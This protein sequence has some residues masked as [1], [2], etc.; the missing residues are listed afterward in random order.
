MYNELGNLIT[1]DGIPFTYDPAKPHQLT[2]AIGGS[3]TH[4][5]NG[6]RLTKAA[7]GQ[8]YTYD[9]DDRVQTIAAGGP[10]VT[11]VYDYT[12][13]RVAQDVGGNVTRYYSPLIEVTKSGWLTKYYTVAG[14][15]IASQRESAPMELAGLPRDPAI[16]LARTD[17]TRPELLFVLRDD[18]QLPLAL[19]VTLLGTTL[20]LAP[21]K[22]KR[23]VGI[24]IR[25]G[26]VIL[27]LMAYGVTTFPLPIFVEPAAAATPTSTRTGTRTPTSTPTQTPTRTA[28]NTATATSTRTPTKTATFTFT[29]TPTKTATPTITQTPTRTATPTQTGTST[30]T[31]TVTT[32]PTRTST[33]TPTTTPTSTATA[34]GGSSTVGVFHYH[35]DHLGSTQAVTDRNG[36]VT[37]YARYA[38]YG[39]PRGHYKADGSAQ[40]INNCSDDGYCREYTGYDTEPISGL[41]Y[42]GARV[43]DPVLGTFLTHDPIPGHPNPYSYVAWNPINE[44][45]PNGECIW[46]LCLDVILI[47]A[48]VGFAVSSIQA[49]ANGATVGQALKAGAIGG[50]IGAVSG[51]GLSVLEFAITPAL[52]PALH[53]LELAGGAY[54][55][56]RGFQSGQYVVGA[57]GVIGIA[58]GLYGLS[59]DLNG[60]AAQGGNGQEGWIPDKG[61]PGSQE[62]AYWKSSDALCP[63][64]AV[65]APDTNIDVTNDPLIREMKGSFTATQGDV[66][67]AQVQAVPSGSIGKGWADTFGNNVR[68]RNDLFSRFPLTTSTEVVGHEFGHVLQWQTPFFGIRYQI[69]TALHGYMN[70]PFEV[71]ADAMGYQFA[72]SFAGR[73]P[74]APSLYGTSPGG[75][76]GAFGVR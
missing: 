73:A 58:F 8:T 40:T 51:A 19:A 32:T 3:V 60:G 1:K 29:R 26:H 61:T 6:N 49:A 10:T 23:V 24:A 12:G 28:T 76:L 55:T 37:E 52:A 68:I 56:V 65:C 63:G 42:A 62:D 22:R 2:S 30:L 13:R 4:D 15:I 71:R 11:F 39:E 41:E 17:A 20:L 14:M 64:S 53:A 7:N 27:V 54:S 59:K 67:A 38:P 50:A 25:H 44:T 16:M 48:V 33:R 74:L 69:Q 9:K 5:P 18:V 21:W 46:D 31:P 34:Q 35:L 75:I 57:V 47:A 66:S 43:Y 45:D 72:A 36:G 70:N